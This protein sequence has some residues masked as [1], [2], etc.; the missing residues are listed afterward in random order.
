MSP[1]SAVCPWLISNLW[2]HGLLTLSHSLVIDLHKVVLKRWVLVV[3]GWKKIHPRILEAL[4]DD[5]KS[6]DPSEEIL[7]A[8]VKTKELVETPQE[9]TL[10]ALYKMWS[11]S[12]LKV[13]DA[14]DWISE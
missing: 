9:D 12:C 3:G 4:A 1:P 10:V 6:A 8:S 13:P 11:H 7:L 14:V 5:R 2:V